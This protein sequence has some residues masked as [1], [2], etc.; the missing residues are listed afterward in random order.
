M[1]S[2]I[3]FFYDKVLKFR[4]CS[5]VVY[6]GKLKKKTDMCSFNLVSII[7]SF[8]GQLYN[9]LPNEILI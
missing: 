9:C 1:S 4:E 8:E 2:V 6:S 3:C 7:S 5:L